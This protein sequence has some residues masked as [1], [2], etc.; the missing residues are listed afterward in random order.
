MY[1]QY[2]YENLLN[3]KL[4][5]ID[6]SFDKRQG[7]IIYD[8]MAPNSAESTKLYAAMDMLMDRTFADTACGEDLERRT[9]ER[10]IKRKNA[11]SAKIKAEFYD[12]EGNDFDVSIGERFLSGKNNYKVCEKISNGIFVLECETEGEEGNNFDEK[13]IPVEYIEGLAYG[14]ILGILIYG[15]EAENDE[16]LRKRYFDSFTDRAFGGNIDDYKKYLSEMDYVGGAKIYP[17]YYGGGTVRVVISTNGNTVP[18]NETIKK[19]QNSLDPVPKGSG[20]GIVPIGHN[21]TVEGC[22]SEKINIAFK[23]TLNSGYTWESIKEEVV[24]AVEEYIA[25][26][27][28]KWADYDRIIVRTSYIEMK[29][30]VVEGV[31]DVEKTTINGKEENY[32]LE[33]DNIP[34][35]GTVEKI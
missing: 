23:I 24:G 29:I 15:E 2:S 1:E 34:I 9:A 22:G 31:L 21:V 19:V 20:L 5:I 13:L 32:S 25:S 16:S 30:L 33:A 10:N 35:L 27:R 18:E 3:E 11:V 28:E 17:A 8:A 12:I 4:S 6:N 26:L 14:K 7:S